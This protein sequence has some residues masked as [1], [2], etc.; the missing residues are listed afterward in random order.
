MT[1][2]E[3][4]ETVHDGVV[5]LH[6]ARAQK[7]NALTGDMYRYLTDALLR[8]SADEHIRVVMLS[9]DGD[10]FC[11]GNDIQGFAAVRDMPYAERP[12]YRFMQTLAAF[13]KPLAVA[14]NGSAVGLG[15][16]M[17]LH[18]DLVYA[19]PD[20]LLKT[21]FVALG[22]VPEFA[23]TLLLPPLLGHARAFEWLVMDKSMS[24]NEASALGI[25]SG[26]YAGDIIDYTL[27]RCQVLARKSVAA[28]L[29]TKSLLKQTQRPFISARIE[30]ETQVLSELLRTNSTVLPASRNG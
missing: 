8:A 24:A 30:T 7:K 16:T 19:V 10:V 13:E 23:S 6:L 1:D 22:L 2:G 18:C 29:G 27:T 28:V 17:L 21:P 9:A 15:V 3:I 25:I 12:G 11:A 14:V 4:I 20:A 5:Q 26:V